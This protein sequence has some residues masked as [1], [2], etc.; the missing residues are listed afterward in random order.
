[1][2]GTSDVDA[3]ARRRYLTIV[4]VRLAG[5]AGAVL[6]VLLL[7]RAASSG[8]KVLGIAIVLSALY[9]IATVPRALAARWR[10]PP[11]P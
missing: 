7:A 4:A 5:S 6:G 1:M 8:P 10:T 11:G 9:M 2:T 3:L